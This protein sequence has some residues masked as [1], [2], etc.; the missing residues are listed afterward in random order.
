MKRTLIATIVMM[1]CSG[2]LVSYKFNG[3][4]IDYTKTK[5]IT[6]NEFPNYAPLV[7]T[8]LT[9][10]LNDAIANK[11]AQQ[12]RLNIVRNGGDLQLDGEITGYQ[13]AATAIGADNR[14]SENKLTLTVKIRFVNNV[15]G[16]EIENQ[17]SAY[18]TFSSSSTLNDVQDG[19][20][21]ELVEEIVDQIF[22]ATVANW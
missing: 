21:S 20:I 14:A 1:I 6:I 11:F 16:D 2:C 3:A 9:I 19:L 15:T 7:Y 22:N 13:L 8:P 10:Q 12:T 17:F 4:S 18:R 5:S